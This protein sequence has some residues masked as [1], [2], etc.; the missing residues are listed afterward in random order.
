MEITAITF[1]FSS[2]ALQAEV[3]GE[4]YAFRKL[5]GKPYIA[6]A[7]YRTEQPLEKQLLQKLQRQAA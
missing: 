5:G 6:N 4:A 7:W 2:I 3:D 1:A